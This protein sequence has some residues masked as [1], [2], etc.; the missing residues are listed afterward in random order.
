MLSCL[1]SFLMD[2]FLSNKQT[3]PPSLLSNHALPEEIPPFFP[4]LQP[5]T[6]WGLLRQPQGAARRQDPGTGHVGTCFTGHDE[7]T[8]RLKIYCRSSEGRDTPTENLMD[9]FSLF[10]PPP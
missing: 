1:F 3:L 6:H 4:P 8:Q 9:A 7:K 5:V 2:D 10:S